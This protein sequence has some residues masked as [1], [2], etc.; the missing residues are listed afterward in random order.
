MSAKLVGKTRRA[1]A[2]VE[3]AVVTPILLTMLFGIVEF[4]WMFTVRQALV[5][6]TREGARTAVLPGSTVQAVEIRIGE[7]LQPL[8]LSGYTTQVATDSG[9]EPDG[10]VS[11]SIPYANVSLVSGY[12]GGLDGDLIA[13]S[14]MRK[15]KV[16]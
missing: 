2:A 10:T 9:G 11:V 6:A 16:D 1:A 13:V 15:E 3:L 7:Y 8:G 4:G 5:T 14:A 12:F